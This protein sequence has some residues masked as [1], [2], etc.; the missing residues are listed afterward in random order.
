[1]K[2]SEVAKASSKVIFDVLPKYL[3][4]DAFPVF[5]EGPEG[6]TRMLKERYDLIFFTGGTKIG[7]IV[8]KAAAEHLTVSFISIFGTYIFYSPVFSSSE[9]K[10]LAGST[11]DTT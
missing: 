1:M 3:N 8:Y 9:D 10:I 7:K 6:A 11:M 5:V 4:S 2:P